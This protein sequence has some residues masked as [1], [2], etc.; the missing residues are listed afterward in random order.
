MSLLIAVVDVS[1]VS[2]LAK[3]VVD[4]EFAKVYFMHWATTVAWGLES[5]QTPR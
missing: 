3:Y 1:L 5:L 4:S 2:V